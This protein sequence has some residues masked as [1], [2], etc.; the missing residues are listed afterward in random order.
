M[1]FNTIESDK[2]EFKKNYLPEPVNVDLV[3]QSYSSKQCPSTT[4][5]MVAAIEEVKMIVLTVVDLR[6]APT[7]A[8]V[9]R[10]LGSTSCL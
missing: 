8:S 10:R 2:V 9:P 5:A 4:P 6:A 3:F 1:D 7:A